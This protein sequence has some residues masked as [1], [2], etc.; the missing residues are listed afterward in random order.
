MVFTYSPGADHI[1][2]VRMLIPDRVT[3]GHVFEDAELQAYLTLEGTVREAAACALETIAAD[4]TMVLKVMKLLDIQTDGARVAD[5]LLKRA[6]LLRKQADDA[7]TAAGGSFDW[8]EM[9]TTD[10]AARERIYN[11]AL[12]DG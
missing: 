5:A 3:P 7:L 10:F 4:Q 2:L 12:R 6:A 8:A 9:V 11:E 1:S